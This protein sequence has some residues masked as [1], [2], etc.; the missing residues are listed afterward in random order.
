MKKKSHS[1]DF[2]FVMILFFVFVVLCVLIVS[3]GS[4]VYKSISDRQSNNNMARTTLSYVANK[5]RQASDNEKVTIEEKNGVT[6]I[7]IYNKSE[8]S[9]YSTLIF[10]RGG[11][12][13]EATIHIGDDYNLD[14]GSNLVALK[15]F[16][17]AIS[18]DGKSLIISVTD[19]KDKTT[20]L[21]IDISDI[22]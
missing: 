4:N 3:I 7:V 13:K 10:Y 12:L 1:I 8:A 20:Y 11:Y 22:N 15:A 2:I 5:V 9:E 21:N 16:T 18:D 19:N 17:P 14:F 6:V